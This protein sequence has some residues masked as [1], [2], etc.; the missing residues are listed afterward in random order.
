[1]LLH[2]FPGRIALTFPL[3]VQEDFSS[4]TFFAEV[5]DAVEA[6]AVNCYVHFLTSFLPHPLV[7][8]GVFSFF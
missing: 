7:G 5:V 2:L 3:L 8:G 1:M 6:T 4:L